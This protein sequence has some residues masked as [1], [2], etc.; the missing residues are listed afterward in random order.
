MIE[1][2]SPLTSYHRLHSTSYRRHHTRCTSAYNTP[3]Y[4]SD[5]SCTDTD[6]PRKRS[7]HCSP[8]TWRK[9]K[10]TKTT[11]RTRRKMRQHTRRTIVC[12]RRACRQGWRRT[13]PCWT[14]SRRTQA[15]C[16]NSGNRQGWMWC[17]EQR[18]TAGGSV[19]QSIPHHGGVLPASLLLAGICKLIIFL[20]TVS[21]SNYF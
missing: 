15:S 12:S 7:A 8:R 18:A 20:C 10:T 5:C 11:R 21:L 6:S 2:L 14:R 13:R 19:G 3:A 9:T 4:S 1:L 17:L 16:P